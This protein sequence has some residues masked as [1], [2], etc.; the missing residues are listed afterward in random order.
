MTLKVMG[1]ILD[2]VIG[3]VLPAAL[4]PSTSN[5]NLYLLGVKVADT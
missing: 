1:S 3:T 2:G 4:W 5:R